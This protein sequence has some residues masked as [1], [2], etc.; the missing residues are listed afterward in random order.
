[1]RPTPRSPRTPLLLV[2]IW[3]LVAASGRG[4]EIPTGPGDGP[5]FR[6]CNG[7]GI[8]DAIDIAL[9]TSADADFDGVPDECQVG[10]RGP[11]LPALPGSGNPG[12]PAAVPA[13]AR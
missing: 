6:D 13:T 9:G 7:N 2:P 11:L 10:L 3:L 5:P 8:E 12:S 1:M 4:A